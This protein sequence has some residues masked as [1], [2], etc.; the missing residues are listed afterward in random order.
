LTFAGLAQADSVFTDNF[1]A[2][3]LTGWTTEGVDTP[4][5]DVSAATGVAVLGDSTDW[6]SALYRGIPLDT[7]AYVLEFDVLNGLSPNDGGGFYDTFFASLYFIDDLSQ[8]DLATPVFDDVVPLFSMDM[9]TRGSFFDV[10][11]DVRLSDLGPGWTRVTYAFE[12]THNY[13]IPTFEL[14]DFNYVPG[15]STVGIDNLSI[16]P[17]PVPE[18]ATLTMVGLGLGGMALCRCLRRRAKNSAA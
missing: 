2:G 17:A 5:G 18:P 16:T 8:F 9:G 13:V 11:F 1:D 3:D 7:G 10:F 15:D 6:Y 4:L 14:F 12:N